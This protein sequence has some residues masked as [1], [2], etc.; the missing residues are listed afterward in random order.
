M[1]KLKVFLAVQEFENQSD[2]QENEWDCWIEKGWSQ[3]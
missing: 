3:F 2:N 1:E